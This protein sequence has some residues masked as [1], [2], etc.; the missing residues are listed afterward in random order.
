MPCSVRTGFGAFIGF[1]DQRQ[2]NEVNFGNT[3]RLS[4]IVPPGVKWT[5]SSGTFLVSTPAFEPAT[6][7]LL[8]VALAGL[9][10]SRCRKLH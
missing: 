7:A 3:A 8:G 9:G 10:F 5:S 1:D 6:L 4:L 2:T